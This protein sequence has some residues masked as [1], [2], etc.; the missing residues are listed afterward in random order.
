MRTVILF[1]TIALGVV[2]LTAVPSAADHNTYF[3]SPQGAPTARAALSAPSALAAPSAPSAPSVPSAPDASVSEGASTTPER[4]SLDV[5][6]KLG[7]N[8]FRIGA[9]LFGKQGYTG[10]AWLNGETRPEG[11]SVDG[12]LEREGGKSWNFKLNADI[13]EALRK[14]MRWWGGTKTDL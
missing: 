3:T 8:G 11:F 2:A 6:L 10:G 9:R 5:D 12:R 1:L 7:V 14:A 4:S 13:D